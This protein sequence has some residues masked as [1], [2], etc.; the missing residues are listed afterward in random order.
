MDVML[1][2]NA[3]R[4]AGLK[5]P[6]FESLQE[7][8][9]RTES[10]LLLARV[11]I[12]E[13]CSQRDREIR[14]SLASLTKV[15]SKL[16]RHFPDLLIPTDTLKVEECVDQYRRELLNCAENVQV[17]EHP[18]HHMDELIHRLAYRVPPASANGEEARDV[19]LWL[20]ACESGKHRE[21]AF[22]SGDKRAFRQ[23]GK[24]RENLADEINTLSHPLHVYETIEDFLR[25]HHRRESSIDKKWISQQLEAE[26]P[27][28]LIDDYIRYREDQFVEPYL[29]DD[30]K[31]RRFL[32]LVQ[33]VQH[34]VDDF[35]VSDISKDEVLVCADV[36]AEL[37][38]E[39]EYECKRS[40]SYDGDWAPLV[41]SGYKCVYPAI[42][43]QIEWKVRGT[44]VVFC[45]IAE[46]E[47]A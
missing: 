40:R 41:E 29:D 13:L 37:E 15:V 35:F 10:S 23:D 27:A 14:D 42:Q 16:Q 12:S 38:I 11:V 45:T 2:T 33:I 3:I 28:N 22:V 8:L 25:A 7:Y 19:L 43:F 30:L 36:W 39:A 32:Q 26:R 46:V 17:A 18:A 6:A 47:R 44:E 24:L 1:D 20:L 34:R 31:P 9:R 5:G 4:S 21:L